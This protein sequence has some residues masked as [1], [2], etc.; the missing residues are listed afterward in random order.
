MFTT[1]CENS[2]LVDYYRIMSWPFEVG[3]L[4]WRNWL[5]CDQRSRTNCRR[6]DSWPSSPSGQQVRPGV[7]ISTNVL[8]HE[9]E[10][11]QRHTPALQ[12]VQLMTSEGA[13]HG[14]WIENVLQVPVIRKNAES[15]GT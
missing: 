3:R 10:S 13:V 6:R 2:L 9:L 1:H 14:Q 12:S 15:A 8:D 11:C 7:V 4:E 5:Y